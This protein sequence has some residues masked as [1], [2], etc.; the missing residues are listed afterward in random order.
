MSIKVPTAREDLTWLFGACE[1]EMG[2]RSSFNSFI[3]ASQR[4]D[5]ADQ[6]S[7]ENEDTIIDALDDRMSA[8]RLGAAGRNRRVMAVY[9]RV[10]VAFQRVLEAAYEARQYPPGIRATFG[11]LAGV[12]PLTPTARALPA[13]S[14]T[15]LTRAIGRQDPRADAIKAEAQALFTAALAAFERA[16]AEAP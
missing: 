12:A 13:W 11:E 16:Q 5:G 14:R 4:G 9:Q 2:V 15:W 3:L 10:D 6:E 7:L 1:S 8:S